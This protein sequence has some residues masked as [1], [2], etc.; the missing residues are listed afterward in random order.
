M[1]IFETHL[2]LSVGDFILGWREKFGDGVINKIGAY[3]DKDFLYLLV[4]IGF[5]ARKKVINVTL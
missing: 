4:H 3:L 5:I 1:F 2:L